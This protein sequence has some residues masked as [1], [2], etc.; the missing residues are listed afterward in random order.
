MRTTFWEVKTRR[1]LQTAFIDFTINIFPG[2]FI[3][4]VPVSLALTVY[5]YRFYSTSTKN[6]V[7]DARELKK[8]Y[9]IYDENRLMIAGTVTFFVIVML[10]LHPVHHKDTAWTALLGAFITIAF[11]NPHDVQ[12][13]L[14]N[15]VE[16]D[17]LLFFTKTFCLS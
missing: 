15:H 9:P 3:F 14:Q 4:C 16:W 13:A 6:R 7:L 1:I 5:I 10:L 8:T 17:T 12:D 2:I 11:T